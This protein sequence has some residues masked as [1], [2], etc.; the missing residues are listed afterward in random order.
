MISA[1]NTAVSGLKAA[2]SRVNDA[3]TTIVRAGAETS[4]AINTDSAAPAAPPVSGAP[5][6][7][8]PV[9]DHDLLTGIL[10]LKQAELAYKANAKLIASLG[11]T[12]REVLDILR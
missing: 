11:E 9:L 7:A 6:N 3:A 1:L 4:N 10:D 12:E 8:A 2:A 5:L